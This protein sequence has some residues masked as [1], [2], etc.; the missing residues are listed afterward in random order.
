MILITLNP[1]IGG[2]LVL[3]CT[4]SNKHSCNYVIIIIT[5]EDYRQ[6]TTYLNLIYK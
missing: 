4:L 3:S 1:K 2:Q 5:A 6:L